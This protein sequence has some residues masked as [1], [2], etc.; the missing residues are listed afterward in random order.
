MLA[1]VLAL[2]TGFAATDQC[3][4]PWLRLESVERNNEP[5][6]MSVFNGFWATDL[7]TG[8]DHGTI[9]GTVP[10]SLMRW[11]GALLGVVGRN[12]TAPDFVW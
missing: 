7:V 10:L 1:C 4:V 11:W 12:P 5:V 3:V 8:L 2:F 6:S 9:T